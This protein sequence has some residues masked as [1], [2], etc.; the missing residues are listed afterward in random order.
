MTINQ[1]RKL[2]AAIIGAVGEAISLGLLPDPASKYLAVA[3]AFLTAVGVYMVPNDPAP[4]TTTPTPNP[5]PEAGAVTLQ[6]VFTIAAVVIFILAA[7]LA[8]GAAG[9]HSDLSTAFGW[10]AVGLALFAAAHL[11]V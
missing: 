3:V 2:V 4:V 7:I 5:E 9:T 6:V 11:P 1:I 8:F 10:S